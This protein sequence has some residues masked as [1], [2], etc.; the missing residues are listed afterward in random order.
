MKKLILILFLFISSVDGFGTL[1][2]PPDSTVKLNKLK[3]LRSDIDALLDNPDFSTGFIGI[4]IQSIETGEYFYRLNDTKNFIP[5]S[6]LKLLTTSAS[7]DY[8]GKDFKFTTKLYL[9]GEIKEN[10]E[11][12][13]NIIIRGGGDPTLSKYFHPNPIS[14]LDKWAIILDSLGINSIKGNI[15]ADDSYL[16]K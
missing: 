9:D 15:I 1:L 7:I 13:G 8:L 4:C 12:T 11:F 2:Q 10:G 14:I 16:M 3:E 6:T 5:A